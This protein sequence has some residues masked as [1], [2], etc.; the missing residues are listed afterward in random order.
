[1]SKARRYQAA[2]PPLRMIVSPESSGSIGATAQFAGVV[3]T[4]EP[5]T[6]VCSLSA[7]DDHS[8]DAAAAAAFADCRVANDPSAP[9]RDDIR[10]DAEVAMSHGPGWS[11]SVS[12][13][14]PC[15]P[16]SPP[17][18]P[19]AQPSGMSIPGSVVGALAGG[20]LGLTGAALVNAGKS[21]SGA[22][23]LAAALVGLLIGSRS[24]L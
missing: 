2:R 4:S 17:D 16:T 8:N 23:G 20:V 12:A 21:A 22:A 7:G 1:M 15:P 19:S 13:P 5:C 24:K 18:Q 3:T 6:S 9:P 14:V 10:R 11:L